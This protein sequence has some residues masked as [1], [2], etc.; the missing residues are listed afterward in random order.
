MDFPLIV[1]KDGAKSEDT[2]IGLCNAIV[3]TRVPLSVF[4]VVRIA[5]GRLF[6][7][8]GGYAAGHELRGLEGI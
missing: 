3:T 2:E 7:R 4:S 8:S 6:V 5:G 1:L